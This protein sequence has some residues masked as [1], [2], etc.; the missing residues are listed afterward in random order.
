MISISFDPIPACDRKPRIQKDAQRM[1]RRSAITAGL[2]KYPL[3]RN[4]AHADAAVVRLLRILSSISELIIYRSQ[5]QERHLRNS[6]DCLSAIQ[7]VKM[8][9]WSISGDPI[10]F[11]PD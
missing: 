4:A 8:L 6:C 11:S 7:I 1:P 2:L 10:Q 9:L 5:P 3:T